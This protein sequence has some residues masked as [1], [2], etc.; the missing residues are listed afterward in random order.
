MAFARSTYIGIAATVL[1]LATVITGLF[2]GVETRKQFREI[3]NSWSTYAEDAEKKGIW[4][5]SI[6]GYLGYGGIIHTFKNYVIRGED[7]HRLRLLEQL[8]QFKTVMNS[9]L[10]IPL[11]Q[12]ERDALL[13]IGQTI[14]TYE[15]KLA[16]AERAARAKWPAE[17]TDRLV[18]VDDTAAIA[19][20][21]DLENIWLESRDQ[22]TDRIVA[23]VATGNRLIEL[24]FAAMLALVLVAS[25]IGI[26]LL[27]LVRDMREAM[28]QLSDELATR[29]RL[30][31]SEKRLAE[32]VEQSPATILITDTGGRIQYANRRFEELSGWKRDEVVGMTPK[33]LQSGDISPEVYSAMRA[34]LAQAKSWRGV[35]RNLRRD[36]GSYWVDTTILPLIDDDGVVRHYLG[37][38]EDIEE[39]RHAREQ[40]A[41]AQKM[42]AVGLLAGGIA[43][44]FNNILTTIIGS[45]HLAALD[46]AQ[47]SDLAGEVEQIDIAARRAQSLVRQLLVFAQ[48]QPGI[49]EPTDLRAVIS[50]VMRLMRAAIPPVVSLKSTDTGSV[51]VLA[52]PTHLHQIL[53]NL[54]GNASEAI[55]ART[56]A[57]S[58]CAKTLATEPEGLP[59]R[60]GGWVELV[61]ADDGPGMSAETKSHLF[62][63]F[64]TTKPIGKGTGLGLAVVHGLVEEIGG[65]ISVESA[66][67]A[68][69]CFSVMLPGADAISVEDAA[70][71]RAV[72]R[73]NERILI[74]DDEIEIAATY[75]RYLIR[76]GY[77]VEAYTAPLVALERFRA[78]PAHYDL[79]ISD[80]LMP[81]MD[82]GELARAMRGLRED[83][84]VIFCTGYNLS[85][86][87]LPDPP[88]VVMNKPVAPDD[89]ARHMR[90]MLDGRSA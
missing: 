38:G 36:G 25:T 34:T 67:G 90:V 63:A 26:L 65:R 20:L 3:S 13:T 23:A 6:R 72:P 88:P 77:Q 50:E 76:L 2:L 16:I 53:M 82:G 56:G 85:T 10:A 74:V 83:L 78:N 19:A 44:D 31:V 29:K 66:P 55:G 43:H 47:D 1:L 86:I 42:E 5:S 18:R 48:R 51:P 87:A 71:A 54:V 4:I 70:S 11:P 8:A 30:E 24:G 17:R 45:A 81:D 14:T 49:A 32:A 28:A 39:K 80:I 7:E 57:I 64:F 60:P 21:R 12:P 79:L 41:R 9:Y 69:A 58:V 35:M 59:P 15:A 37:I 52:D 61:V 73:G 46:A 40:L 89:L 62:D 75:R 27:V 22:S 33:L 68:G 84:P